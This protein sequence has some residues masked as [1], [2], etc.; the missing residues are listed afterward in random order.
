MVGYY[1]L[2]AQVIQVVQ[3]DTDIGLCNVRVRAERACRVIDNE[4][5]FVR[6]WF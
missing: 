2:L 5:E 4:A 6:V 3:W 1:E